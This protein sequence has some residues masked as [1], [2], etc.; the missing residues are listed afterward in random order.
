M[1]S[2]KQLPYRFIPVMAMFLLV[3]C[4]E[5]GGDIGSDSII[6][7]DATRM[8][9]A[10]EFASVDS[11]GKSLWQAWESRSGELRRKDIAFLRRELEGLGKKP[12]ADN[13]DVFRLLTISK[14]AREYGLELKAAPEFYSSAEAKRIADNVLSYQTPSGGWSKNLDM[15]LGPRSP[16][17]TYGPGRRGYQPTFDNGGTSTQLRFLARMVTATGDTRYRDSFLRGLHLVLS[18]QMPNGGWPQSYPLDGGYHDLITY[19]DDSAINLLT[20][21]RAVANAEFDYQFV[22][23]AEREGARQA[24]ARGIECLLA[25]QVIVGGERTVWG[26]QQDPH[27]FEL[28]AARAF[29]PAS[30]VS[31]ESAKILLFLMEEP[32]PS[33]EIQQAV[34]AGMQ[35]F[36]RTQIDGVDWNRQE[37]LKPDADAK[38]LWARFY[39]PGTNIPIFGDRDGRIYRDVMALSE[40]RR[41]GYSWYRTTPGKLEKKYRQWRRDL[42][43][44]ASAAY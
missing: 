13:R 32:A 29:E 18:A 8:G 23:D 4:V 11:A 25:S 34:D 21:L 36:R 14:G 37:G 10:G 1:V 16:G 42:E 2:L 28:A 20:L 9:D 5:K 40:E 41:L 35:W 7:A 12:A 26:A 38:P 6:A 3:A 15:T 22:P 19:N 44:A 39:E 24:I 31:S 30:L 17:Y 43:V 27:T 33:A